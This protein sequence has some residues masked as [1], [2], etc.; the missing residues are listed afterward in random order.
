MRFLQ[1]EMACVF[2]LLL[3]GV[4]LHVFC[5]TIFRPHCSFLLYFISLFLELLYYF[6]YYLLLRVF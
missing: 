5:H 6:Q 3:P 1:V 2:D 4:C